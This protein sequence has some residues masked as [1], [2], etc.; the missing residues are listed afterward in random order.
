[1]VLSEEFILDCL[2]ARE[3]CQ[4]RRDW[5]VQGS[6]EK[7]GSPCSARGLQFQAE[8][9]GEEIIVCNVYICFNR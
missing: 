3:G 5:L 1:M 6:N 4:R 2:R 9:N 7:Y 8:K